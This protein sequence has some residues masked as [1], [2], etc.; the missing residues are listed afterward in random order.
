MRTS[1]WL[2]IVRHWSSVL[3]V[4]GVALLLSTVLVVRLST[5]LTAASE[6]DA[7]AGSGVTLQTSQPATDG[8]VFAQDLVLEPGQSVQACVQVRTT[9]AGT[10][11]GVTL[12]INRAAVQDN[13]LA[14]L[15]QLR[16]E[17][18]RGSDFTSTQNG[19][20][21]GFDPEQ[22]VMSDSLADVVALDA[23]PVW[24]PPTG[25]ADTHFRFTARLSG[26]I[27]NE[28]QGE[29][30]DGID[31]RFVA[32]AEAADVAW[33]DKTSLVLNTLVRDRAQPIFG[34]ILLAVVLAAVQAAVAGSRRARESDLAR[35][36]DFEPPS[37][38]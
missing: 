27:G 21:R 2:L 31:L 1:K 22:L 23:R 6:I 26:A 4:V 34:M 5:T 13:P 18:G 36:H 10:D 20:C 24:V 32:T 28:F 30:V 8:P 29:R 19:S 11:R 37:L 38:A 3:A 12:D 33:V 15:L 25:E 14:Q 9:T 16:V 35:A 7:T 17:R